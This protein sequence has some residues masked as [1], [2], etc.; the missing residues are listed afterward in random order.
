MKTI[1]T[2]ELKAKLDRGENF[3]L[4]MAFEGWRFEAVHIPGSMSVASAA[5]ARECLSLEDEIVV[6]CTSRDCM[7][8]QVLYHE[9][10]RAGYKNVCRYS[11][12]LYGWREAGYALEGDRLPEE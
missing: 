2:E 5:A 1:T 11:D 4:V 10:E 7:A 6:Y 12:G 3:K 9:L 8:S